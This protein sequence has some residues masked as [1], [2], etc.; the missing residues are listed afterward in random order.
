MDSTLSEFCDEPE[1]PPSIIQD[2]RDEAEQVEIL[3][4]VIATPGTFGFEKARKPGP[5]NV[6]LG[7]CDVLFVYSILSI[8]MSMCRA[9]VLSHLFLYWEMKGQGRRS[10]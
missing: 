3:S 9:R 4:Q 5:Q 2:R 1:I 6:W 7:F 10:Y 8:L